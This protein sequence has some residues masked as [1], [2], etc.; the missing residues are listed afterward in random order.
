MKSLTVV[1]TLL[2][3]S[4]SASAVEPHGPKATTQPGTPIA[5]PGAVVIPEIDTGSIAI[6]AVQGTKG[7]PKIGPAVVIVELYGQAGKIRTIETKLDAHGV[8]LIEHLPLIAPFRPR[9]FVKHGGVA[10]SQDGEVMNADNPTQDI[11]VKV[12]ETTDKNPKWSVAMWH[13]VLLPAEKGGMKVTELLVVNNPADSAYLGAPNADGRQT[14]IALAM[15]KGAKGITMSGALEDWSTSV[16]GDSLVSKAPIIPGLSQFHLNYIVPRPDGTAEVNLVAPAAA[17]Q[18]MVF[19]PKGSKG[20]KSDTLKAGELV[21]ISK[22]SMQVYAVSNVSEG[23]KISFSVGA[24]AGPV[25]TSMPAVPNDGSGVISVRAVQGT[26]GGPNIA[27]GDVTVELYGRGGKLRTIEAKLDANGRAI[28]TNLSLGATF[29]PKVIVKHAGGSYAKIGERMDAGHPVQNITVK[30]FETSDK[31][32]QWNI[33]MWHLVMKPGEK[34]VTRVAESLWITNPADS[35]YL[36]APDSDGRRTSIALSLAKGAKDVTT[37]GALD[38]S[39]VSVVDGRLLSNAPIIPGMS[40]LD[41]TYTLLGPDGTATID[42]VAP[43]AAKQLM[44]FVPRGSEGFKSDILKMGD[45]VSVGDK[46]MRAYTASDVSAGQKISFAIGTLARV[47]DAPADGSGLIVVKAVQ[48]TEGGPKIVSGDVSVA[49]SMHGG[50]PRT[51]TAKLDANGKA[52]IKNLP[53][54]MAFE[55]KVT[56]EYADVSYTE[57]GE[58]MDAGHPTQNITVRVFEVSDKAPQLEVGMWHLILAP[59]KN[60]G[61]EVVETLALRN[62]SDSTYLGPADSEGRR[63][64][65]ALTLPKGV[66][67]VEQMGGALHECCASVVDGRVLSK[68]PLTPGTSEL[69]LGYI[70]PTPE[71]KADVRLV[72]C[73][74]TKQLLV[75]VPKGL[76]GFES[77]SLKVSKIAMRGS[78]MQAYVLSDIAA[79]QEIS[80]TLSGMPKPLPKGSTLPATLAKWGGLILLVLCV[81]V[82]LAVFLIRKPNADADADAA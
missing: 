74:A 71:G 2:L 61:L 38:D 24:L 33:A 6:K 55:P 65:V 52:V 41:I 32:P 40:P 8:V 59:G 82:L 44:I 29:Q 4:V 15:A 63:V 79:G 80:F 34:G 49:I 76:D 31:N 73:A 42:L 78:D 14:A 5:K 72:A 26:K 9:V 7:G 37:S 70:V 3:L 47:P 51:I 12:F 67:K 39:S 60:G 30:V 66:L 54:G 16:I 17:K 22:R 64:S 25:A 35:A 21:N 50:A 77:E 53:L 1:A 19:V 81:A 27:G 56:V 45:V 75:L 68:A 10:Y 23:Q 62:K 13:L 18:L 11:S 57:V 20:L 43:A 36:G 58:V 48:G 69:K 46:P 28:I